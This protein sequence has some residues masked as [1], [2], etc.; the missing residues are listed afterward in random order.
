MPKHEQDFGEYSDLF[1]PIKEQPL[2]AWDRLTIAKIKAGNCTNRDWIEWFRKTLRNE[3][4][5]V[6]FSKIFQPDLQNP[7]LGCS[8]VCE[9]ANAFIDDDCKRVQTLCFIEAFISERIDDVFDKLPFSHS[10]P[11]Q[12]PLVTVYNTLR[13]VQLD[14]VEKEELAE[15][16]EKY[17]TT[18]V[19]NYD[20]YRKANAK[21]VNQL[22]ASIRKGEK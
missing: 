13:Q 1:R 19:R 18:V 22:L 3:A 9:I 8:T 12:H 14:F 2:P 17:N 21:R 4:T 7:V 5:Q 11:S 16:V 20:E 15:E 10:V 6:V